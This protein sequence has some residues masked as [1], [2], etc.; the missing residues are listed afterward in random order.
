[1]I[2]CEQQNVVEFTH[3]ISKEREN[4]KGFVNNVF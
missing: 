1:M 3:L 2:I 4:N